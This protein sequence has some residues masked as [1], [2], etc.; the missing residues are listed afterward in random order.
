VGSIRRRT[1]S[2]RM[3]NRV[4]SQTPHWGR[5]R[6]HGARVSL[7]VGHGPRTPVTPIASGGGGAGGNGGGVAGLPTLGPIIPRQLPPFIAYDRAD[8]GIWLMKPD[9]SDAHEVGPPNAA[10]PVWSPD[11]SEILYTAPAPPSDQNVTDDLY[12]MNADGSDQRL[13]MPSAGFMWDDSGFQWSPDGKQIIFTEGVEDG[14]S[15]IAIV[16]ADGT[17][18]AF[19]FPV[20]GWSDDAT[21][22]PD[23]NYIAFGSEPDQPNPVA[24]E[25]N[26]YVGK[27]DGT[28]AQQI[29][30][31][32][33]ALYPRWSPDGNSLIYSCDLDSNGRGDPT[34]H[35][36]YTDPT[37][38]IFGGPTW[39]ATGSEILLTIGETDGT[40]QVALLS[41][42]G[43]TPTE[44][45]HP[46]GSNASSDW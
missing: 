45:T 5:K 13:I 34:P 11:A 16:N 38:T 33:G 7:L 24:S 44:I 2:A 30:N 18:A 42:S 26:I 20:V 3:T 43:G 29:T 27:R 15:W 36:L 46:P 12:V 14:A 6:A 28:V 37:R 8:A 21:Y 31:G 25:S 17:P 10:N 9:G 35:T 41:P 40:Y 22:A 23:G 4:L 1:S 32:G 39:N 19:S